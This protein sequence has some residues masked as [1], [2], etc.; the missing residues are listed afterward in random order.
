MKRL[1]SFTRTDVLQDGVERGAGHYWQ[2]GGAGMATKKKVSD[3]EL[4]R[5]AGTS[6]KP[7]KLS[8]KQ[9]TDTA[10]GVGHKHG[11]GAIEAEKAKSHQKG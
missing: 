9:G 4:Y 10:L 5:Q 11:S 6:G 7:E 3:E 8:H 2:Q 1:F